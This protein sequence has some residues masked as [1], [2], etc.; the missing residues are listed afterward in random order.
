MGTS[1]SEATIFSEGMFRRFETD[2]GA[3]A[4]KLGIPR[5]LFHR[6]D[7]EISIPKYHRLLD[8]TARSTNP[9][10]GFAIGSTMAAGDLGPLG[11]AITTCASVRQMLNLL[12][13]YLYVFAHANILRVDVGQ[14]LMLVSYAVTD[15]NVALHQ[16]DVELAIAYAAGQIRTQSATEVSP[17]L[18]EFEHPRPDYHATLQQFFRCEVRYNRN[19]NRLH[20]AKRVLDLPIPGSDPSL[21]QALEFYLADRLKVRSEETELGRKVRH[22]I[23]TSLSDGLPDIDSIART[24]GLSG[25]TLQRRLHAEK[26]VFSEMVES[27]R[28]DIATEY[29][30]HGDLSLTDIAL[31]LAYSELSAFSR[32]FKR[33]TGRSPQQYRESSTQEQEEY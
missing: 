13:Q 26:L 33:W 30:R 20:Y 8:C 17:K 4:D 23:S 27:V 19:A 3:C 10:I 7:V 5:G 28:R 24:L 29:V 1:V 15:P 32:A 18:V 12:S 11:H 14:K 22:L 2:M 31:M 25:R 9:S 21:L 6:P 16:Q